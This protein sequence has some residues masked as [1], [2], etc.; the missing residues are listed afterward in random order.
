MG[1]FLKYFIHQGLEGGGRIS[2]AEGHHE[3]LKMA[4]MSPKCDLLNIMRI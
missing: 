1:N 4:M 2:E 3:E